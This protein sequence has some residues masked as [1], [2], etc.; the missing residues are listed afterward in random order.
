M[1][2]NHKYIY[3]YIYM[4]KCNIFVGFDHYNYS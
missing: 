1:I 4:Y 2:K 3:M